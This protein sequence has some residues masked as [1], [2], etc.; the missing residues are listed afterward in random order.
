MKEGESRQHLI[1][2]CIGKTIG[3]SRKEVDR[4]I[5]MIPNKI[6]SNEDFYVPVVKQ[7]IKEAKKEGIRV[8]PEDVLKMREAGWF[9]R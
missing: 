4:H 2:K 7:E 8:F 5:V 6:H 9:R 3:M 1:P